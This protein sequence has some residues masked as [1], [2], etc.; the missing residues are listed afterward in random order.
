MSMTAALPM[1]AFRTRRSV[2]AWEA[3]KIVLAVVTF[4]ALLLPVAFPS[5]AGARDA[6]R[7]TVT[8]LSAVDTAPSYMTAEKGI[9]KVAVKVAVPPLP[10][11]RPAL[12]G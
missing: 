7:P 4:A 2:Y 3:A 11:R 8:R 1:T 5:K 10:A 12:R 9:E 6:A